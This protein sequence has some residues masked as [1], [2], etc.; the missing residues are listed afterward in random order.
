MS[1][2]NEHAILKSM[3]M[4]KTYY[5]SILSNVQPKFKYRT[6]RGN[7]Q[8]LDQSGNSVREDLSSFASFSNDQNSRTNNQRIGQSERSNIRTSGQRGASQGK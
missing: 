7:Q 6:R 1:D 4:K 5:N 8:N 3:D 2:L